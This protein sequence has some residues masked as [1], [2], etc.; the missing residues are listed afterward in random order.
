MEPWLGGKK[1]NALSF[2]AWRSV[3]SNG[4]P[5]RYKKHVFDANGDLQFKREI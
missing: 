1:A 4:I 5:K 2:S 3:Q